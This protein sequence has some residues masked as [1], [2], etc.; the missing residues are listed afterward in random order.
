MRSWTPTPA[1]RRVI[2]K[3]ILSTCD[4]GWNDTATAKASIAR[5]AS[6]SVMKR[7]ERGSGRGDITSSLR[8]HR[9]QACVGPRKLAAAQQLHRL[10]QRARGVARLLLQGAIAIQRFMAGRVRFVVAEV[11]VE[12]GH[13]TGRD[14][15]HVLGP[16]DQD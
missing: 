10:H 15:A 8:S 12:L 16:V 3:P 7:G 5:V 6:V 11:A 4:P 14:Q 2:A 13:G 9:L 1:S